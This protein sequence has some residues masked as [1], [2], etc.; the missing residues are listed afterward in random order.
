MRTR[1]VRCR[2][3][4]AIIA[5]PLAR[6]RLRGCLLARVA[7]GGR[8]ALGVLPLIALLPLHR[9]HAQSLRIT[10]SADLAFGTVAPRQLRTVLPADAGAAV[11]T[12]TGRAGAVLQATLT[13]PNQLVASTG[14]ASVSSWTATTA[15]GTGGA[16]VVV[17]PASGTPFSVTLG[18]DGIATI[19][20][21]GTLQPPIATAGGS[22]SAAVTF[23][24]SD[25]TTGANS[26]TTQ[27][28]VSATILAPLNVLATPLTFP[29]VYGG[30][31]AVLE[32]AAATALRLIIDG[33]LNAS[34]DVT[35]DALP[36]E[37]SRGDGPTVPVGSWVHRTGAECTGAAVNTTSGQ[38][39]T[40]SLASPV[41]SSGRN[42]VC[43]GGT[44]MPAALQPGG[45]Y[46]G[47]IAVTIRYTGA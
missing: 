47:T 39:V 7:H 22:F 20:L 30:V 18:A 25:L 13:F 2:P 45:M 24:A 8:R 26:L 11:F 42:T 4:R 3:I 41:G 23:V 21:G 38:S 5:Q 29:R 37:L 12:I 14:L 27:A 19:R 6:N 28:L 17:T 10:K 46:T 43:L 31:P 16:P 44:V 36:S 32:P 15:T 33:P 34:V 9:L 1:P 35:F 40:L